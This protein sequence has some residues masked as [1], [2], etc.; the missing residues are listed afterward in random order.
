MKIAVIVPSTSKNRDWK[1]P[2][3]SYLNLM[4]STFRET[5]DDEH[6]YCFF[7]GVDDTDAY[8]LK[9]QPDFEATEGVR[10]VPVSVEKGYVTHIWN[11]LAKIAVEE[12]FDYLFQCGDDV[13]LETKGW[14]NK[15][16][17]VLQAINNI[18]VTGPNDRNNMRILTQSFVHRTHYELFKFYFPPEIPNWY[19]DDW[20]T[21]IYDDRTVRL[22]SEYT[23]FNTGGQ[24]RYDVVHCRDLCTRLVRRD[25]KILNNLLGLH[26]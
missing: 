4:L 24:P 15:C 25:K 21:E 20:I 18:G 14:V 13:R 1:T 5:C 16:I 10:I 11:S 9:Y 8:Y 19:C 2:E 3:D 22:A 12:G 17:E 23:C 6:E 7:V 26:Q